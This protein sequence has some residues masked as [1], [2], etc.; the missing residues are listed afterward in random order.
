MNDP[1]DREPGAPP[2]CRSLAVHRAASFWYATSVV[3]AVPNT[4]IPIAYSD[5]Q[6]RQG[7][8][9]LSIAA[10]RHHPTTTLLQFDSCNRVVDDREAV[11]LVDP[12]RPWQR[13]GVGGELDADPIG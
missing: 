4:T 3:P 1:V 8:A 11:A 2:G 10:G 13:I 9:I 6:L 7:E 5:Q 12:S